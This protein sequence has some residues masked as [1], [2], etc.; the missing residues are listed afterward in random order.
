V[1]VLVLHN[2][3]GDDAAVDAQDV[4]NQRDA[5]LAALRSRGIAAKASACTLNLKALRIA[6]RDYQPDLVFNLVESLDETDRLMPLVPLL[7][8]ALNVPYTGASAAAMLET[9]NKVAAKEQLRQAALPTPAW[10]LEDAQPPMG[11]LE[12]QKWIIKPIWE[13]ASL[14]MCDDAVVAP[15]DVADLR[16]C[17][18]Q[19]QMRMGCPLLAEQYVDG[20]EFNLSLLAG[21]V[22]PPAEIDFSAFP[23]DKPRIVGHAAKWDEHSFEYRQTPR[24][25]Q[26][27]ASDDGLLA[28]LRELARQCWELFGLT[29]FARID[30]RVDE[31]GQP[32]ILEVNVNPCLSPDAGFAAA[33]GTAGIRF[34]DA[35]L[36][37]LDEAMKTAG[38]TIASP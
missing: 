14:G 3:P 1:K 17:L 33:L 13:H 38:V 35:V 34:E 7:L 8:D 11:M 28:T 4:L 21:E 25:F 2:H 36:Q 31:A 10:Y 15:V 6:V 5:I 32:W 26:F 23:P 19:R 22:L 20:R 12:H 16:R 30:F 18:L 27:P 29:G 9:G 24:R 37:I